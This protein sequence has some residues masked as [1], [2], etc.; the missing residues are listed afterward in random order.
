MLMKYFFLSIGYLQAIYIFSQEKISDE[1][2]CGIHFFSKNPLSESSIREL[3]GNHI[4]WLIL[5]PY[6][7]QRAYNV[8]NLKT[9]QYEGYE[10]SE[11]DEGIIQISE[12]AIQNDLKIAIKPHIWLRRNKDGKWRSE[13]DFEDE[14]DWKQWKKQYENW[15]LHCAELA[16]RV[17]AGIF[18]IG[19]ELRTTVK[20]QPE[21]WHNLIEKVRKVYTGKL[22]YAANWY[23]EY[24]EVTFWKKLDYIGIQAYFPLSK[25]EHFSKKSLKSAWREYSKQIFLLEEKI[26]KPILF[27]EIGYK[28]TIDAA[29]TPWKWPWNQNE[30]IRSYTMQKLCYE[31]FFEVFWNKP[32]FKG[33]F[34][35][36]WKDKENFDFLQEKGF[37]PQKKPALSVIKYWF[38]R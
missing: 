6:A 21:F 23:Q 26:N 37:T 22:C 13:I 9:S 14:S 3:K 27:T 17:G 8:P 11:R 16:Q 20:K 34:I 15:I 24:E 36:Q 5:V 12:K 29:I 25:N 10:F 35:W 2:I 33:V 7:Y 1:R 18:C 31:A 30:F 38:S 4:K 28:S 32:W 19:T